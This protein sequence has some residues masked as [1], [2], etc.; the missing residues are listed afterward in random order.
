MSKKSKLATF[1]AIAVLGLSSQAGAATV[2]EIKYD[3]EVKACVAEIQ[4]HVNYDDASRVHHDVVLVKR[5]L[6]GYV[7][8]IDTSIY[9]ESADDATREYATYCVVNG[10]HKPMKFEISEID[11][12]A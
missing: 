1:A 9:T 10:N 5:K 6:V 2:D 3:S 12:G 4:G 8:K 11:A 7:M